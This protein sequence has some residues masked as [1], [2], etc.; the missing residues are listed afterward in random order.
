MN[1]FEVFESTPGK[2]AYIAMAR[3]CVPEKDV[4]LDWIEQFRSLPE[5]NELVIKGHHIRYPYLSIVGEFS[6][7][8]EAM[9]GGAENVL[10]RDAPD[11]EVCTALLAYLNGFL[12]TS[13]SLAYLVDVLGDTKDEIWEYSRRLLRIFY[14]LV[15]AS[16]DARVRL[17]AE[18]KDAICLSCVNGEHCGMEGDSLSRTMEAVWIRNCVEYCDNVNVLRTDSFC[19]AGVDA[20]LPVE[21]NMSMNDFRQSLIALYPTAQHLV[22]DMLPAGD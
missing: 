20:E 10:D 13:L 4:L 3:N 9:I 7:I 21:V 14:D 22:P 17:T 5:T 6:Q 11:G 2:D 1:K 12:R 15:Y 8:R 16:G 19:F 18:N